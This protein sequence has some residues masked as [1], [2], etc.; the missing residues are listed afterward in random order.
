MRDRAFY[1]Y[2]CFQIVIDR[3]LDYAMSDPDVTVDDLINYMLAYKAFVN[4]RFVEID[5]SKN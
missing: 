4:R 5:C 3:F 1:K 2:S